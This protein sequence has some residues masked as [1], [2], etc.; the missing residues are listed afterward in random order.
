MSRPAPAVA[1]VVHH[2][3]CDA[4]ACFR[5]P[6]RYFALAG[7][8]VDLYIGVTAQHLAPTFD[9]ANV[10]L[11]PTSMSRTGALRLMAALVQRRPRYTL[12]LTAPTWALYWATRAARLTGTP[13]GYISDEII[14]DSELTSPS[15]HKWKARERAA[16]RQCAFTIALSA[17]RGEYLRAVNGLAA[18]HPVF[19]VP[20]APTGPARRLDSHYYRDTLSLPIGRP[21]ALH[22]GGMGWKPLRDLVDEAESWE[23]SECS[24]A[25]MSGSPRLAAP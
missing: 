5:E 20:N 14:V 3:Y 21:V 4:L 25:R 11:R 6:M 16:H 12:M 10:R 18:D 19:V 9:G 24:L 1:F 22:A 15:H 23:Q 8:D 13:V 2:A 7:W 17:E